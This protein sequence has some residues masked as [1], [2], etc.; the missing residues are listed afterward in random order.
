MF[1][2][3]KVIE[4]VWLCGASMP[5]GDGV[6]TLVIEFVVWFVLVYKVVSMNIRTSGRISKS[7]EVRYF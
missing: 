2:Y 1:Y 4:M 5:I 3:F 7:N 6:D